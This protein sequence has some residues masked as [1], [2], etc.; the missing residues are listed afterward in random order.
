MRFARGHPSDL[1]SVLLRA[2]I[3][4]L[5][6]ECFGPCVAPCHQHDFVGVCLPSDVVQ[7]LHDGAHN[8]AS[9]ELGQ[10]DN[11]FDH[12]KRAPAVAHIWKNVQRCHCD[13]LFVDFCT[14]NR[15]IIARSHL[16]KIRGICDGDVRVQDVAEVND[17]VR[18]ACRQLADRRDQALRHPAS[19]MAAR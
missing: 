13:N 19:T 2:R 11:V 16:R 1:H 18:V 10:G 15:Q 17:G 7:L 6:V 14:H 9:L 4:Q 3:P 5:F 8:P 12:A